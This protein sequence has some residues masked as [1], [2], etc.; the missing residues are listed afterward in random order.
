MTKLGPSLRYMLAA[1]TTMNIV[2]SMSRDT[3]GESYA[4]R[5]H[6]NLSDPASGRAKRI[7][8]F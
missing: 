6:F 1:S 2:G 7:F 3:E 4:I 8:D 5:V